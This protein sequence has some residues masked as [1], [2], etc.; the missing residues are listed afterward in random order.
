MSSEKISNEV[1]DEDA[2]EPL[3]IRCAKSDCASD[4]HY[5]LATKKMRNNN[6]LPRCRDCG[7]DLIDWNQVRQRDLSD[8][9][10]TFKLLKYEWVRH[11]YWHR[12]IDQRAVNY[13]LRKG[14]IELF[15]TAE[16]IIRKNI[17]KPA[18]VYGNLA[19]S[20]EGNAIHYAQHATATC[21]RKCI[22]KWHGIPL[23]Q[24]LTEDQI[25]YFTKL[26]ILYL[27][28]RFPDLPDKG[29]KVPPIRSGDKSRK[30]KGKND[31]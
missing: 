23:D 7:V 5:F 8:V 9:K 13:A 24:T 20:I 2:L 31:H 22:E 10:N 15:E 25:V 26:V 28:E 1:D 6:E 11:V 27:K 17:A 12:K 30:Q 16:H 19:T 21:C 29:Q 4:R 18:D 14:K 3:K